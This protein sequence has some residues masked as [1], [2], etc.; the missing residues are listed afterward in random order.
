MTKSAILTYW[1][2]WRNRVIEHVTRLVF[3]WMTSLTIHFNIVRF[4]II[5]FDPILTRYARGVNFVIEFTQVFFFCYLF[6]PLCLQMSVQCGKWIFNHDFYLSVYVDSDTST[7]QERKV[8]KS[9]FLC[10]NNYHLKNWVFKAMP[11]NK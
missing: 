6:C 8:V 3:Q 9:F 2:R 7:S 10:Q 4:F 5:T 11:F 1:K